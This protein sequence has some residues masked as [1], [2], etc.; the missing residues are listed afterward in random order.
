MQ[1]QIIADIE[2]EKIGIYRSIDNLKDIKSEKSDEAKVSVATVLVFVI[3]QLVF[4]NE[5]V[6][7]IDSVRII[8]GESDIGIFEAFVLSV[9]KRKSIYQ[10]CPT[11]I[12]NRHF[13]VFMVVNL[14]QSGQARRKKSG[15]FRRM[16][17]NSIVFCLGK[18]RCRKHDRE[19][20]Y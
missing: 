5:T 15:F 2:V 12:D 6:E 10:I 16:D 4:G 7:L 13:P 14:S 11:G 3:Q 18:G 19:K 1:R 8:V 20:D 9:V 17:G